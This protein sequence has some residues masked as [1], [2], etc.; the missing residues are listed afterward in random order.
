[1][2]SLPRSRRP[3][4]TLIEL[5]DVIAIIAILNALLLPAVQQAREAARRTQC[6]N[7]LKQLGLAL[8]NYLDAMS[9]FPPLCGIGPG[10]GGKWSAWARVLPYIDQSAL[11]NLA[12]LNVNYSNSTVWG[13]GVSNWD[14]TKMK[15]P[16]LVCPSDPNDRVRDGGA[17]QSHYPVTYGVN[18]GTWRTYTHPAMLG[19]GGTQGDGAFAANS[20]FS[21]R[22]FTDGMSNTLCAAE[23]KAFT[24]SCTVA[25]KPPEGTPV[26]DSVA[27]LIGLASGATGNGN[28]HT[29]WVD[30]KAHET[31]FTTVFTP[32]TV[33]QLTF[34]ITAI[35]PTAAPY[36]AD[37]V[38]TR[39]SNAA[40]ALGLSTFAAVTSRSFHTGIVQGLLMDGSARTFSN[41]IDLGVWRSLSTRGGGEVL[42]DF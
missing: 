27:T 37:F 30:G 40:T 2:N 7:N 11:Y 35:S 24:P 8:H 29:E 36:N 26:P 15:M 33:V 31:G 16:V 4:L 3:G 18:L 12:N 34:V 14:L 28:G 38:S 22:D 42:G 25:T 23:V 6:K 32:N 9:V 17:G 39:E 19:G 41:N 5:L 21:S 1:M 20:R 10:D 13:G